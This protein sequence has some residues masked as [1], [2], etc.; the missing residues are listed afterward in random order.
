MIIDKSLDSP[1]YLQLYEYYKGVIVEGELKS[2]DK[3]PS[4]RYL[5]D[6]LG[7]SVN[8]VTKSY[9]LLEEEGFIRAVER[10]GYFVEELSNIQVGQPAL[11]TKFYKEKKPKEEII[12]DFS[13]NAIA[14]DQFPFYTFSKLYRQIFDKHTE[15][16]LMS[17]EPNGKPEFKLA[18]SK[19]LS[20]SRGLVVNPNNIVISSGIEYLFQI[21]FY[22]FSIDNVFGVENPGYDVL[23]PM[24]KSG[25]FGVV[26]IEVGVEGINIDELYKSKAN[27]LSITPS[28]QFPTGTI[29]PISN[30]L[31]ILNW[32]NQSSN[33]Y[34]IED[35]Y[36]S[37]FRYVGKPIDPLKSLD[38][39]DKVIYMGSFSKSVAP[40]LR[41]SYMI[42]PESLMEILS[43]D[44][45]FFICSVPVV[46]QMLMAE[47]LNNGHFERHLNKMRRIY[48]RNREI[49]IKLLENESKILNISGAD[50]GIHIVVEFDTDK[51]DIQLKEEFL[52]NGISISPLSE[53]YSG[54]I[55]SQSKFILGFGGMSKDKLAMG[56]NKIIQIL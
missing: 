46:E 12:Y 36:D 47:F 39:E 9:Y 29:M 49:A 22:I 40:S 2:G 37:E 31:K 17:S 26:P 53:Y 56:I 8:T 4:K 1:L 50:A 25:G 18:I 14:W 3:L 43:K 33:N 15:N 52:K 55:P 10:K 48:K 23:P 19:Y 30:R 28:H 20:Q 35:D 13:S 41:I 32:A 34:V 54:G 42:L 11:E 24:I 7:L 16:I 27:I 44:A 21:L 6:S 38:T 5:S 45:P 51:S